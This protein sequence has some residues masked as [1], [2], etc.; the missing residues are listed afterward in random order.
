V[1]SKAH[2]QVAAVA[3]GCSAGGVEALSRLLPAL[4]P[5]GGVPVLIV[6]HLPRE[7]PSRLIEVFSDRC[8]LKV[9]EAEDK[10]PAEPGTVYFA[11]PDYHLLLDA[12]P[13]IALSADEPVHFCRPAVDVLFE[14]AADLYGDQLLA[15]V[16][17][18]ANQ[19]GAAGLLHAHRAG[20]MTLVQRPESAAASAMPKAALAAV[21]SSGVLEL[22]ELAEVLS[23]LRGGRCPSAYFEPRSS[24]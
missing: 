24:S 23:A 15:I 21:P 9:V 10:Q 20:G 3:I 6:V 12:G 1:S 22:P 8:R 13:Q 16:L 11:P 2:R 7:R 18:G 5:T 19:D 4:E 14:S 17:S